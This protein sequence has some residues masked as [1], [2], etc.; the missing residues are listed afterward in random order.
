MGPAARAVMRRHDAA[1]AKYRRWKIASRIVTCVLIAAALL[2]VVAI[3][4]IANGLGSASV[5][6]FVPAGLL[7]PWLLW[8][9]E[10]LSLL[11]RPGCPQFPAEMLRIAQ[12][13]DDRAANPQ[14]FGSL[15]PDPRSRPRNW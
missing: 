8:N 5:L 14:P 2:P 7:V 11:G 6:N 15:P 3:L 4:I 10:I 9:D 12:A 13:D 1:L